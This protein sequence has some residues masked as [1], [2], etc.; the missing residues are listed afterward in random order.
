[1]KLNFASQQKLIIVN[2]IENWL[3]YIPK[4]SEPYKLS[5][6]LTGLSLCHF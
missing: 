4:T 3:L 1:M 5:N 2:E 6:A